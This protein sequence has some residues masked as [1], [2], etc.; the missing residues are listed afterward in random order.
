MDLAATEGRAKFDRQLALGSGIFVRSAAWPWLRQRA[1]LDLGL[2]QG[3]VPLALLTFNVGVEV[4]QLLFIAG[5][6]GV[7]Q[8][9][10]QFRI[11]DIFEFRLRI[12][13]AYGIG[14]VAAFLF[15]ERF[16]GFWV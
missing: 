8:L 10:K 9:V 7:M 15:I 3:D 5:V 6:L 14:T 16:A 12:V 11:P 4:G 2:P 1:D 13:T